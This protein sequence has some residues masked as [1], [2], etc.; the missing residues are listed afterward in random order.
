MD[1]PGTDA[2][3]GGKQRAAPRHPAKQEE[4]RVREIGEGELEV[5]KEHS[6]TGE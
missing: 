5:T 4:I 6:E 3:A 1:G 2:D